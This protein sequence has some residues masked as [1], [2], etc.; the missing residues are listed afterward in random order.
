[1]LVTDYGSALLGPWAALTDLTVVGIGQET[2][3]AVQ[4]TASL[5][6]RAQLL[7]CEERRRV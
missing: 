4:G 5:E 1:M 2:E 3:G 6:A 7:P